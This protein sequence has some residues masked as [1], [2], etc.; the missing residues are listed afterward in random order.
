MQHIINSSP[1]LS[2]CGRTALIWQLKLWEKE[3]SYDS[4][5]PRDMSMFELL[6]D[7]GADPNIQILDVQ[8]Q[9]H[10]HTILINYS[11]ICVQL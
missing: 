10:I 7:S 9:T 3:Q 8:K 6:M 4:F 1:S 5:K 2:Q 11:H